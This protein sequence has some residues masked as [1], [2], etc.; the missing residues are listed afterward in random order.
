MAL[1]LSFIVG[2]DVN[3]SNFISATPPPLLL[4]P[5]LSLLFSC[6]TDDMPLTTVLKAPMA[7]AQSSPYISLANPFLDHQ[8][9]Q[10]TPECFRPDKRSNLLKWPISQPLMQAKLVAS[11]LDIATK[12]ISL[13]RAPS[14][15]VFRFNQP[16]FSLP[17]LKRS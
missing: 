14:L 12:L 6:C 8:L 7:S 9:F 3:Q 10:L 1:S 15:T 5:P 2:G 13:R 11:F 17:R 4:T 16:N